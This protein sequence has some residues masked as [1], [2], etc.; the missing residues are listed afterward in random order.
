[1]RRGRGGAPRA[2]LALLGRVPV[3]A[4]IRL[5]IVA[6][7]AAPAAAQS[8]PDLAPESF[9]ESVEVEVVNV[10][11]RVSDRK[12]RPI[13]GLTRDDFELYEDGRRVEITYFAEV[14]EG[15]LHAPAGPAPSEVPSTPDAPV[16]DRGPAAAPA[17][18]PRDFVIFLDLGH[19]TPAG[20]KKTFDGLRTFVDDLL[21]PRDRVMVVERQQNL[22]V[23]L[24]L[25][26]DH[27]RVS[28]ELAAAAEAA[29][30]GIQYVT[31][32]RALL[33]GVRQAL[34]QD[35][36]VTSCTQFE[37]QVAEQVIHQHAG[38]VGGQVQ[39]TIGALT[40][41]VRALAGLPGNKTVLYVGEGLD[42][43]PAAEYFHMLAE[44][45]PVNRQAIQSNLLSHDLS[46]DF[47]R[48]AAEANS[49]RVTFYT[50]DAAGLQ[51]GGSVEGFDRHVRLQTVDLRM[52]EANRQSPLYQM[53]NETGGRA[54][55]NTNEFEGELGEISEDVSRYYSLGFVPEHRGDGRVHSI[56]VELDARHH[57]LRYRRAYRDK[58]RPERIVEAMLGALLFGVE[59]NPLRVRVDAGVAVAG[60]GG[61]WEVPIRVVVPLEPVVLVPG[62]GFSVGR[63]RLVLA[64]LEPDGEWTAVRQRDLPFKLSEEEASAGVPRFYE[65]MMDLPS[66]ESLVAVGVRDEQGGE[67]SYLRLPVEI[68]PGGAGADG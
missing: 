60:P 46:T 11:V 13:T 53:A 38:W 63:L 32:R 36:P 33:R 62:A 10:E 31:E 28:E 40:S 16:T 64:A 65:V 7:V 1:M 52:A 8:D 25:T 29:P 54:V 2:L 35:D 41:L 3:R 61:R 44:L 47:H 27:A 15:A 30:L 21:R 18:D 49:N 9:S 55:F 37:A 58:P 23:R 68:S 19:L 5:A 59:E 57:D 34:E 20:M 67:A 42:Q 56:R 39:G 22:R 4:A 24:E 48:M 12:G 43:R 26:D 50:L 17:A 45:C 66:G 51:A 6:A 14:D